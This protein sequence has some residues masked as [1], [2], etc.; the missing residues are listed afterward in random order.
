MKLHDV[1][2]N[3]RGEQAH[4]ENKFA[5]VGGVESHARR[6]AMLFALWEKLAPDVPCWDPA[7]AYKVP[8]VT[9]VPVAGGHKVCVK[10]FH[11]ALEFNG[12]HV[13]SGMFV[14]WFADQVWRLVEQHLKD[15]RDLPVDTLSSLYL[16]LRFR[17]PV[18]R[19]AGEWAKVRC[20]HCGARYG[21]YGT[22]FCPLCGQL[23]EN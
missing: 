19:R 15:F 2:L 8:H 14:L 12:T 4:S 20:V 11:P 13:S 21:F 9:R 18:C 23:D 1:Y 3:F 16:V 10:V 6:V 22:D 5:L 17:C 7:H